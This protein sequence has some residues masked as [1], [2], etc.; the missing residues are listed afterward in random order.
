VTRERVALTLRHRTFRVPLQGFQRR[1]VPLR[2]L[3]AAAAARGLSAALPP[4]GYVEDM[5]ANRT[6]EFSAFWQ[7]CLLRFVRA[8]LG[9][10]AAAGDALA[11]AAE[12]RE[13]SSEEEEEA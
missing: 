7:L 4:G 1:S 3:L 12:A 13:A 6:E 5:F 2:S 11:D 9:E 10:A 8:P